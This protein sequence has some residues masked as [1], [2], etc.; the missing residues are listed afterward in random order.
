MDDK[1]N[2]LAQLLDNYIESK[3]FLTDAY[4]SN[5][6]DKSLNLGMQW[7]NIKETFKRFL[8]EYLSKNACYS[9]ENLDFKSFIEE[10]KYFDQLIIYSIQMENQSASSSGAKS[11]SMP[12]E[13]LILNEDLSDSGETGLEFKMNQ[14]HFKQQQQ[15]NK[16][17][18]QNQ[19]QSFQEYYAQ[20]M[21]RINDKSNLRPIIVDASDVA[22]SGTNKQVFLISRIKQVVDYFE[23]RNHQIYVILPQWRKEQIMQTASSSEQ[24]LILQEME[25]KNQVYYSPSKRVGG[26]RIVCDDDSYILNLA[27]SKQGII[28]FYLNK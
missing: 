21:N 23:K 18:Q 19:Q 9:F 11:N 15:Q 5:L 25:E 16:P 17:K 14:L 2:Q 8:L 20:S 1:Q 4:I 10:S 3:L 24:T 6:L 28:Q 27:V 26:K 7:E 22:S 13:D 12:E